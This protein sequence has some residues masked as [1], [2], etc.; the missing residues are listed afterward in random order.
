M[1]VCFTSVEILLMGYSEVILQR[2]HDGGNY[3]TPKDPKTSK[4]KLKK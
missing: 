1:A 3:K 4:M 2:E